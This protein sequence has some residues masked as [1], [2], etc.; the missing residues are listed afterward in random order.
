MEQVNF[1]LSKDE[2]QVVDAIAAE[3]GVSAAELARRLLL[4]EIEPIRV[5]LAFKLL[6]NGKIGRKKAWIISGLSHNEFL[7]EW[8][9]RGAEE[10]IPDEFMDKE[11]EIAR[12]ID[13]KKFM[14]DQPE[15]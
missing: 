14:R 4:K 6:A 13:L 11:L 7:I 10:Q 3:R 1:R 8:T 12:S 9:K 15:A 5:D 2:K